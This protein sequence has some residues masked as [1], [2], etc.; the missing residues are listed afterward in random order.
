MPAV[1]ALQ[2]RTL[3]AVQALPLRGFLAV[4]P[5]GKES[6]A[7]PAGQ[8]WHPLVSLVVVPADA[9]SRASQVAFYEEVGHVPP[10]HWKA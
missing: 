3:P 9:E 10:T 5:A 7:L 4:E 2:D 1:Q 6:M 8:A